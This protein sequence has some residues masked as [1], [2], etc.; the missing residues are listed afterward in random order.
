MDTTLSGSGINIY[1]GLSY[2]AATNNFA[3]LENSTFNGNVYGAAAA[4][5]SV[6]DKHEYGTDNEGKGVNQAVS[7]DHFIP[8]TTIPTIS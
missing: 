3:I 5:G 8:T 1:G 2:G 4:L 6:L 7:G